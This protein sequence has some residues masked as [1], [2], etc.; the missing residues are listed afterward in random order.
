RKQ[1]PPKRSRQSERA[2]SRTASSVG[3]ALARL[4]LATAR[5]QLGETL[6]FLAL[7]QRLEHRRQVAV[8]HG[9]RR[10]LDLSLLRT[11][12]QQFDPLLRERHGQ[13]ALV[14]FPIRYAHAHEILPT[15]LVVGER[16]PRAWFLEQWPSLV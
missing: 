2:A 13:F 3:A 7:S 5:S 6:R 11:G 16:Q 10:G 14:G 12:L 1:P 9:Q 4:R 15:G 8:G